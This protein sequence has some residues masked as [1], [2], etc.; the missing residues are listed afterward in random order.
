MMSSKK[1]APINLVKICEEMG[2]VPIVFPL[3]KGYKPDP[4]E[5]AKLKQ[6][7]KDFNNYLRMKERLEKRHSKSNI[8]FDYAF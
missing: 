8:M 4:R 3:K 2:M 1:K 7:F 6:G 5:D